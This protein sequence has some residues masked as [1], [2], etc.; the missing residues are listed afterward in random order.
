[1]WNQE[2]DDRLMEML[3]ER[4]ARASRTS[5]IEYT[6]AT[7]PL[8]DAASHVREIA[9]Y[10][11]AIERRETDRLIIVE[12]PRHGKSL[13]VSQRFPAWWLGRSPT[14]EVIHCSY[15]GELATGFGR[16][17]RNLM[18][19][20]EHR[21]IFPGCELAVDSKAANTWHTSQDG[22]Y[23]AAGV[24]GAITGRGADL[25]LIDDPVKSREEAESETMRNRTWDWY[26][27][28]AYT[29][30]MPGGVVVIVSTRWHEDD[31]VGRLLK[32]Q[33]HGGDQWTVLHH[34]AI[35]TEGE[36]LW[37]EKF[38]MPILERIR[39]VLT[40]TKGA[41]AWQSLYQGDPAP[42]QGTYFSRDWFRRGILP[43]LD[44]MTYYGASDYAVTDA[45]GDYTV[46]LVVGIDPVGRM[47]VVDMWRK[48][49]SSDK[50]IAP[51][52]D[53]MERWKPQMWAEEAGQIEKAVGP[54]LLQE[55]MARKVYVL[56]HQ[57]SSSKDKPSRA[58][59]I[60]ARVAYRGLYMPIGAPW[61][62]EIETE[63]LKFPTG[64]N[65][66]IVD[67]LS[68]IGRMIAGMVEGKEELP[69]EPITSHGDMSLNQLV[70][71]EDDR[72]A[73]W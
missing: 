26:L 58:R 49:T 69:E 45:G 32:E 22:V 65:D 55:Q 12:P 53:L 5:L 62:D 21:S 33:S 48:Q 10:L 13:L 70:S 17:L 67:T 38:T 7:F 2:H 39:K 6:K 40:V 19:S 59:A 15:G 23:I 46:H 68:L 11:E 60:Q 73:R 27:N 72:M 1:M 8:Y 52:L 3:A 56:R 63:L 36:A 66:D 24:G 29:R 20:Q 41:N 54:F 18:M 47:W 30:L 71:L 16:R 14:E 9:S 44:S 34:P 37:P 28:D 51:M 57:F 43:A 64:A 42:D 25:L 61:A 31:L 50:W 4:K 35:N